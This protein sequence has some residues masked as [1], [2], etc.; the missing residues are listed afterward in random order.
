MTTVLL[1]RHATTAWIG[2]ALAGRTAGV[3]ITEHGRTQAERLAKRLANGGIA[4]IYSSPLQ[5]ALETAAPL[6]RTLGL[7]VIE[8]SR[9][10]EVDFGSWTGKT[11]AELDSDPLWKRFN[12]LRSITRA[13]GGELAAEIQVRMCEELEAIRQDHVNQTVAVFSHQDA[14]KCALAHY[15]GMPLDLF[16]RFEIHPASISMVTLADW[17]IRLLSMND[18]GAFV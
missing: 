3:G 9:L 11:L 10:S 12:S 16:H 2:K 6:S 1:I 7:P 13:P 8:R 5:R 4:A 17:G 15:L 14:I 18:T